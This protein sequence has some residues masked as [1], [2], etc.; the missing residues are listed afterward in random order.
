[1]P[2][3]LRT[4]PSC[5]TSSSATTRASAQQGWRAVAAIL[6]GAAAA[7]CE[8]A[9]P[10]GIPNVVR[11]VASPERVRLAAGDS[12]QRNRSVS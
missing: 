3:A 4:I 10:V 8:P 11:V 5:T 9:E 12:V 1:M 2:P 7:A 6:M